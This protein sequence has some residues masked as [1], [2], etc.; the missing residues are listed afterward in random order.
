[1]TYFEFPA[2][3]G[4]NKKAFT[5]NTSNIIL[6]AGAMGTGKSFALVCRLIYNALKYPGL[7]QVIL[8]QYRASL[9]TSI[10]PLVDELYYK[11]Y[12]W[13]KRVQPSSRSQYKFHNHSTIDVTGLDS[14]ERFYSSNYNIIFMFEAT[15]LE[16]EN[17]VAALSRCRKEYR[18]V[19]NQVFCD[20]NP[21]DSQHYLK[22][23]VEEGKITHYKSEHKDNPTV[24]KDYID[25]L[26]LY[27]GFKRERYLYGKWVAAEGLIFDNY[28]KAIVED[29]EV[30]GIKIAG[31]DFGYTDP[32]AVVYGI[33]K[34]GNLTIVKDIK[35]T[36]RKAEEVIA[37]KDYIYICDSSRP[38]SIADINKA[39]F[40]TAPSKKG[41]N[42]IQ[43]GI[44]QIN[45]W[46]NTGRLKINKS[47]T[48]LIEEMTK[49]SYDSK[50][51]KPVDKDNHSIDALRYLCS[52]AGQVFEQK[53]KPVPPTYV[54]IGV[55]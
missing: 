21:A 5:D 52:Y 31:L 22:K 48:S 51:G 25:K 17:F 47:C 2:L 40:R 38:D 23:W 15:E 1:M 44:D 24:N 8:R 6:L 16:E 32:L 54:S 35:V 36:Q 50:T 18:G 11:I 28:E 14:P 19:K 7:S 55:R 37:D 13:Q 39:G 42:S 20:C 29:N 9:T 10:I 34:D 33:L 41:P 3:Y 49:Y 46:I 53:R 30:Q 45:E 43:N 12:P 26:E 4:G 27:T